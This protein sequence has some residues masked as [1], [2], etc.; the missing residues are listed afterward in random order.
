MCKMFS[1]NLQYLKIWWRAQKSQLVASNGSLMRTWGWSGQTIN[2]NFYIWKFLFLWCF[3]D[4]FHKLLQMKVSKLK[5]TQ[6]K[7][8]QNFTWVQSKQQ[9]VCIII[10]LIYMHLVWYYLSWFLVF[11]RKWKEFRYLLVVGLF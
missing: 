8:V 9:V 11:L 3:A 1:R 5:I 4:F 6:D 10:K 2:L 7:L